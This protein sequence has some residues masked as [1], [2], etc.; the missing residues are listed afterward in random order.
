MK[1]Y[2]NWIWTKAWGLKEEKAPLEV[3]FRRRV[4]LDKEI[5]EA[6]ISISAD[7]RYKLYV[8]GRFV[9][10][11]PSKGDGQIWFYDTI[12]IKPFL[13]K[14]EN[15]LAVIVL[16]FPQNP[17]EGN[18]SIMCTNTAGLFLEGCIKDEGGKAYDISADDRWKCIIDRQTRFIREAAGFAPLHFYEEV[19][20][21]EKITN[22]KQIGY[23]DS[24]WEPARPY[25]RVQIRDAVSPG[26]LN[27]RTIPFMRRKKGRFLRVTA[28]RKSELGVKAYDCM[29][30]G[31]K[32][33]EIAPH[34]EEIVE[35]DAGEEMTGYLHLIMEEGK[36]A[37]IKLMEAE[38]YIQPD[39]PG[40]GLTPFKGDRLDA[41]NGILEGYTDCYEPAGNGDETDPEEYEP[42]WFRTF[43]FIRLHM[44]TGEK[45]LRIKDF[46][47]EETGYPL[48][49][50]SWA[51]TSDASMADIWEISA[52]TLKRCMHETYMDCP[53]Y[54][55]LQYVMDSRSQILYTYG[56]SLD[57]RLAK[58]C[59]DDFKR[60]Q[61]YDGL[62]YSA[63]PNTRPN[64]IPGFSIFYICMLHDHMMYFGD[65]NLIQY[66]MPSV[67]QVLYYFEKNRT[68]EGYVGKT[69]GI[70]HQDKYWSFIDWAPQWKAGVP[71]AI[72]KGPLTMESLLYLMGLLKGA[73]L[74]EYIGRT[75][76][77]GEYRN[78]ADGVRK[79][80]RYHCMSQDHWI[81][82]GPG[83]EEYSQHCQ[84]FGMLTGVLDLETGRKNLLE[85]L[86]HREHYAQCTVSMALYLFRALEITG[87]YEETKDCWN[88][89]RQMIKSH[90]T[91]VAESDQYPRSE[92]H[93][94]GALALYELPAVVLGVRPAAPGFEKISVHP[95]PGCFTWAR[96]QVVTPGGMVRVEWER[97]NE[98]E[99]RTRVTANRNVLPSIIKEDG[100]E[101]RLE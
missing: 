46:Y 83:V 10:A 11:G 60:A 95:V 82:D 99:M 72:R 64:V 17:S 54:E 71:N 93:G 32:T 73:E 9:E 15:V 91:T 57:D 42:F 89:W 81:Q 101:Y 90:M 51:E 59:M 35:I 44:K 29:L 5:E 55:Q 47:F 23:D 97:G 86:K 3:F 12:S 94:W 66:H 77:A 37:V 56:I 52:R 43:R 2:S 85:T 39:L 14:G 13:T 30:S 31:T 88:I 28:L 1:E 8:N 6:E 20:G 69:G 38:A 25:R 76:L 67:E 34:R 92:C 4:S 53:F 33:L 40:K 18:Q 62:L 24:F 63:Y 78:R 74:A 48:D 96:G 84:V 45:P 49:I 27:P 75:E 87:L 16:R 98:G 65:K 79:S 26:N 7:S 80:I 58:K 70:Y 68:K 61:R 50:K 21:D 19:R 100:V 41:Q 36:G 22:W